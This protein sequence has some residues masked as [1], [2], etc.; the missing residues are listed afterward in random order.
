[1]VDPN[2]RYSATSTDGNAIVLDSADPTND[3]NTFTV[4]GGVTETLTGSITSGSGTNKNNA[5]IA[6]DQ[7]VL[8]NGGGTLVLANAT[9]TPN[10]WSGTTTVVGRR[11]AEHRRP[12][13]DR[14]RRPRARRRHHGRHA[15]PDQRGRHGLR[16]EPGRDARRRRRHRVGDE[17]RPG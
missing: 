13:R 1:M 12:D 5:T 7:T 3:P 15:D 10:T 14:H 2:V 6:Q 4:D 9:G 17:R 8:V 16:H 11:D